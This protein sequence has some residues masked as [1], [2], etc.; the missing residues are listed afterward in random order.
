MRRRQRGCPTDAQFD[1]D[2]R[3]QGSHAHPDGLGQV[4]RFCLSLGVTPVFA[5]PREHGPQNLHESFNHLW[6]Q[7][8]W[9]RFHHASVPAFQATSDRFVAAYRQRRATRDDQAPPRRAFPKRWRLDWQQRPSGTVIYLRRTNP[10][11]AIQVLGHRWA[12]DRFWV[13]GW[14]APKWIWRPIKSAAT[15]CAGTHR[16]ISHWSKLSNMCFR[17][18]PF[19]PPDQ[20]QM[21]L[22]R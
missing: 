17:T 19:I 22:A 15:A 5:P 13:P 1:N 12:V 18:S 2:T 3:F 7:K 9:Q 6:Q 11:G 20:H 16:R 8:V 14:C 10:E 21:A 4:I